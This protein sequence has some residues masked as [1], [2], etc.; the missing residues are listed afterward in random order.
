MSDDECPICLETIAPADRVELDCRHAF[1]IEC[2]SKWVNHNHSRCPS[3]NGQIGLSSEP[4]GKLTVFIGQLNECIDDF[5]GGLMVG[6]AVVGHTAMVSL[7]PGDFRGWYTALWV[8]GFVFQKNAKAVTA[9]LLM[10]LNLLYLCTWTDVC[11]RLYPDD[12]TVLLNAELLC[13]LLAY[14]LPLPGFR[15]PARLQLVARVKAD[16]LPSVGSGIGFVLYWGRSFLIWLIAIVALTRFLGTGASL[17]RP[18]QELYLAHVRP[19]F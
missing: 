3:C 15:L 13:W 17:V 19:L 7:M 10:R 16:T 6:I 12:A 11:L 9:A 5:R 1:C 8:L 4:H 18:A 2:L 14:N